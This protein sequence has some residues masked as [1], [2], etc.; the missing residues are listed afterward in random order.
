M[1]SIKLVMSELEASSC[2]SSFCQFV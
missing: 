2:S 1:S